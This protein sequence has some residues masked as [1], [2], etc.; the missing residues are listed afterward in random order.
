MPTTDTASS[1]T[2]KQVLLSLL[3]VADSGSGLSV[4]SGSSSFVAL[5][6]WTE[7]II[8]VCVSIVCVC[9]G[10]GSR[11]VGPHSWG[12]GSPSWGWWGVPTVGVG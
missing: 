6:S 8:S 1:G 3:S 11:G 5:S 9:W 10:G 2:R 7:C 12:G 4:S